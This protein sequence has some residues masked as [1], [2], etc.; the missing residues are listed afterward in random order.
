MYNWQPIEKHTIKGNG[1]D[2]DD[3]IATNSGYPD[4]IPHDPIKGAV[5]ALQNL[6]SMGYKIWIY[7][8]RPWSD[9]QNIESYC[10]EHDIPARRIICGKPLFKCIIDDKNVAFNG[11]WE[12]ALVDV[13]FLE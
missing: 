12:K 13:L 4:F 9:Y 3:T 5:Q 1:V 8:A 6:D 10:I 11:N 2:F 7:T